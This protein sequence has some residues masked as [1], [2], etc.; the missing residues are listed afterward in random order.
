MRKLPEPNFKRLKPL[1]RPQHRM[2]WRGKVMAISTSHAM[3]KLGTQLADSM[4]RL[5]SQPGLTRRWLARK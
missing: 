5:S 3:R 1:I 4:H 2:R